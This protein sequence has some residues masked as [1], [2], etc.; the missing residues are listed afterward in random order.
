MELKLQHKNL[1]LYSWCSPTTKFSSKSISVSAFDLDGTLITSNIKSKDPNDFEW[2][3]KNIPTKLSELS[4]SDDR[5]V[6]IFTNQGGIEK[7]KTSVQ[8]I[9]ERLQAIL[10]EIYKNSSYFN[11]VVCVA[12]S[13]KD[14]YRKPC[15]GMWNYINS[16]FEIDICKE[17][18]FFVGD[19]AGRIKGWKKGAKCDFSC[20]DR[21]FAHNVG[22]NFFTPDRQGSPLL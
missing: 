14:H 7:G 4:T 18:S 5:L 15:T 8:F 22:I 3:Y 19:A 16:I 10:N 12:S 13:M 1:G 21:K 11:F 20:S 2:K 17:N 6:V 9:Q